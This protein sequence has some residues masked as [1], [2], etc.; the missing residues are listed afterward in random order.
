MKYEAEIWYLW[1]IYDDGFDYD[2]KISV[3]YF[4][5]LPRYRQY[6]VFKMMTSTMTLKFQFH[7]SYRYQDIGN[8]ISSK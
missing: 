3:S 5:S 1:V 8:F 2:I 6:H 7:T 4:I